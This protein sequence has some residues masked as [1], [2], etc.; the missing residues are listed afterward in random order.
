MIFEDAENAAR[1][2]PFQIRLQRELVKNQM[3]IDVMKFCHHLIPG[4]TELLQFFPAGDG[5][6]C[7]RITPADFL[8][9]D[10]AKDSKFIYNL[11]IC[12]HRRDV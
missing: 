9:A 10:S 5:V 8:C 11:R 12:I 1:L 2:D 4:G 3:M 7:F 6:M